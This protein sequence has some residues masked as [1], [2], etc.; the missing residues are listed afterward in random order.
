MAVEILTARGAEILPHIPDAARLRI[1]VFREYPYLYLGTPEHE[2]EYLRTYAQCA[3]SF[4]VIAKS[5]GRVVGVST[6]MPL[7]AE[8]EE[9]QRPFL[10]AGIPVE[11]V[12]YFGESV[13]EPAMRGQGIGVR[14]MAEREAEARRTPGI[15]R[16]VFCAVDRPADHPLRPAGYVPLD[17]FWQRRG[18]TKTALQTQFTWREEGESAATPKTLTFWEKRLIRGGSLEP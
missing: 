4:F 8:T 12:F 1:S 3:G 6:S 5:A 14:F 2:H 10:A 17:D 18:F 16:A 13:L 7:A 11:E 15:R 9:V